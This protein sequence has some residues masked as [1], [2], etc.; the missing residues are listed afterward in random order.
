MWGR[1]LPEC[2]GM[3]V[4]RDSVTV[5]YIV[6]K[7]YGNQ[8]M[9]NFIEERRASA[10][11]CS[12]VRHP[13]SWTILVAL[14]CQSQLL[15]VQRAALRW[16]CSIWEVLTLVWGCHTA[17]AYSSGL[18]RVLYAVS[19]TFNILVLIFRR[20]TPSERLAFPVIRSTCGFQEREPEMSTPRYLA[21]VTDSKTWFIRRVIYPLIITSGR[22]HSKTLFTTNERRSKIARTRPPISASFSKKSRT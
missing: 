15:T 8:S 21:L 18:T 13:R 22:R 12:N 9:N 2:H 19:S 6:W 20:T 5:L 11:L 10:R 14:A 1:D 4:P 3:T 7:G 17:E 16:T